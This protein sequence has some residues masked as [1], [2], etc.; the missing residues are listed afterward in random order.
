M[1][2]SWIVSRSFD[3]FDANK[4]KHFNFSTSLLYITQRPQYQHLNVTVALVRT[5][6]T[7]IVVYVNHNPYRKVC[8]YVLIWECSCDA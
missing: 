7:F 1:E 3:T 6:R 2:Y 4:M 8:L 5:Y